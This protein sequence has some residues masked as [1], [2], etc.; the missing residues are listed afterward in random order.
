MNAWHVTRKDLKLLVRDKRTL[1]VLVALPLVFIAILGL[2]TG[3]LF[4]LREKARKV[5][6]GVV[7]E[8]QSELSGKL[9]TEVYKLEAL[10][11]QELPRRDEAK[12]MLVD[13][14]I[15]VYVIIGRHYHERVE[16]LDVG[17]LFYSEEENWRGS[18]RTSTLKF[19]PGPCWP[20]PRTSSGSSSSP[21][22]SGRFRRMSSRTPTR[23]WRKNCS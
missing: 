7:N 2:S 16:D 22:R 23:S 15:D 13:G 14:D 20:M 12:R 4:S 1:F 9:L 17:D 10:Q 19:A 5:R 6:L 8:D 18:W 3:Q 11:T 21:S